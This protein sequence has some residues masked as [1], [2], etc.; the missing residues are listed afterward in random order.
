MFV[1]RNGNWFSGSLNVG[2]KSEFNI[3]LLKLLSLILPFST[4][5]WSDNTGWAKCLSAVNTGLLMKVVPVQALK[6]PLIRNLG[7]GSRLMVNMTLLL[8][9]TRNVPK[10]QFNVGLGGP[11]SQ[12][13]EKK[14][15]FFSELE[16]GSSTL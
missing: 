6:A 11:Q 9:Y 16:P 5:D 15:I 12:I 7:A 1:V 8:I 10:Y 2:Y 3:Q 14:K 4:L 13:S